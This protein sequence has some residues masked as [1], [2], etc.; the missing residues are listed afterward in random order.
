MITSS[1][2]AVYATSETSFTTPIPSISLLNLARK[3]SKIKIKIKGEIGLP[4]LTPRL[5]GKHGPS[6]LLI[7]TFAFCFAV[8]AIKKFV[9]LG[10]NPTCCKTFNIKS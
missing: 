8:I 10:P 6:I 1:A 5:S 4:C 7:L 2:Y 3:V 9:A